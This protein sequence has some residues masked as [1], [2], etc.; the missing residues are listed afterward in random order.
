MELNWDNEGVEQQR[1]KVEEEEKDRN[2][3]N[4][5]SLDWPLEWNLK[6]MF[7]T[8]VGQ[9]IAELEQCNE[10]VGKRPEPQKSLFT[11][12]KTKDIKVQGTRFV[13]SKI[14]ISL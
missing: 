4:S 7:K 13:S 3:G 9:T 6:E 14:Y 11:P 1:T 12:W 2:Y 8:N 5:F 10:R